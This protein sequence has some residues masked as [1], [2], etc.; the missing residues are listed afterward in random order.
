MGRAKS[1]RVAVT[2][3]AMPVRLSQ[4][5]VN[6]ETKDFLA[7]IMDMKTSIKKVYHLFMGFQNALN[8]ESI[9]GL[10]LSTKASLNMLM[11]WR[12]D[13]YFIAFDLGPILVHCE[14]QHDS[15][16]VP[17]MDLPTIQK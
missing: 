17:K 2:G 12:A 10:N 16:V 13:I 14:H 8:Y 11:F 1:E 9:V 5:P 7:Q 15:K 3:K 4:T 6:L